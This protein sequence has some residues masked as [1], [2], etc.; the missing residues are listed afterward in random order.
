MEIKGYF[1]LISTAGKR[2]LLLSFLDILV[3]PMILNE[4]FLAIRL[5]IKG[6][7]EK[8]ARAVS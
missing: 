4:V 1:L 5:F 6:F 2:R 3:L 8:P 7:D